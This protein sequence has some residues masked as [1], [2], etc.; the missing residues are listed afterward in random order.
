MG[1]LASSREAGLKP[2]AGR[3][4]RL[5]TG[6]LASAL[7]VAYTRLM[8][9]DTGGLE[10]ALIR[11]QTAETYT[12][13]PG[14]ADAG[15]V[16]LCDHASRLIPPEYSD[17]GLPA[18]QLERHIA[19][20]IGTAAV[21]RALSAKLGVPAVL[22][23]YSRLL[24]DLN[25]GL[26][27]PTLIMRISDGAVVPGNRHLDAAERERRITRFYRPYHD[28]IGKLLTQCEGCGPRPAILSMHSFTPVWKGS[29]RPWHAAVLWD[30]D[31]RLAGPLLDRLRE[32]AMLIV[33]DNEPYSGRLQGDTMWQHGTRRDLAHALVE[34]RQDL[35]TD[36]A[37]QADWAERLATIMAGLIP[38]LSPVTR[39]SATRSAPPLQPQDTP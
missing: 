9:D 1:W 18:A 4:K 14:R 12:V 33:G 32:D 17:L 15:L 28:A 36:P 38:G 20:D 19:Y 2:V 37:G 25:R 29:P 21:T 26:D 39:A 13:L 5:R 3:G 34:I 24:I 35:I 6:R 7:G 31:R 22:S 8:P 30:Q 23:H 10:A 27:D 11:A 16:I